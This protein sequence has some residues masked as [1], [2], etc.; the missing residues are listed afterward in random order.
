MNDQKMLDL[1]RLFT[2]WTCPECDAESEV[3]LTDLPH[4]GTPI[5][6]HCDNDMNLKGAFL[7]VT[8]PLP[9]NSPEDITI[10]RKT[11]ETVADVIGSD[12]RGLGFKD[13]V[14]RIS[15]DIYKNTDC[16]A[17]FNMKGLTISL[18]SIVEGSDAEIHYEYDVA[19]AYSTE[20]LKKWVTDTIEKIEEEANQLWNE[21]NG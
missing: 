16:G 13:S 12:I 8:K 4:I 20:K 3:P 10:Q 9:I 17:S 7:N 6:G 1:N 21:A 15:R 5:C 14:K 19:P 11:L 2:I 18:G